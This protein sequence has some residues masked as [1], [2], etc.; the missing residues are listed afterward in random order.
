M[1]SLDG[2]VTSHKVRDFWNGIKQAIQ[3]RPIEVVMSVHGLTMDLD[4]G[5]GSRLFVKFFGD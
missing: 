2:S 4:L 3:A 1:L 5:E